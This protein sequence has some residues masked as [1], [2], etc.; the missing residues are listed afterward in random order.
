MITI[1]N[2]R[3]SLTGKNEARTITELTDD[4]LCID[5][6]C[7][8]K[9]PDVGS[10]DCMRCIV[11]NISEHGNAGRIRL[12]TSKDIELSGV[13]AEMMCE[14]AMLYRSTMPLSIHGMRSCQDCNNSCTKVMEL[15]WSGFPDPNFDSAR[16]RLTS[17]HPSKNECNSCIQR[18]YRFLDQTELGFDNLRKRIS[19]EVARNGGV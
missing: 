6:R 8:K 12:R 17:F 3:S 2:L 15:I 19:L 11:W 9:V 4:V 16:G 7:C 14:L 18:T 5:C 1:D 10:S 13:S